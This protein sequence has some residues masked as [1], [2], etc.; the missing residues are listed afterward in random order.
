MSVLGE[1]GVGNLWGPPR[2][3]VHG[4]ICALVEME[5]QVGLGSARNWIFPLT[6]PILPQFCTFHGRLLV[7]IT[8]AGA[9]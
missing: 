7:G 1:M 9:A 6:A 5:E 4:Q 3:P 8:L 2:A